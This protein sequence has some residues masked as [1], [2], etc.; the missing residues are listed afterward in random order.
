[1]EFL[2]V[3][4]DTDLMRSTFIAIGLARFI[5][6]LL[7]IGSGLEVRIQDQGSAYIIMLPISIEALEAEVS[8][9]GL[10]PLLRAIKKKPSEKETEK[11][12]ADSDNQLKYKYVPNGFRKDMIAD[13]ELEQTKRDKVRANNQTRDQEA[14]EVLSPD[15]P[16]WAHLVSYFGKGS[17]MKKVYPSLLHTWHAHEGENAVALFRIII[18]HFGQIPHDTAQSLHVWETNILK[19]LTYQ[20]FEIETMVSTASVVSPTGVQ[21]N[22]RE[23]VAEKLNN[24]PAEIFWLEMYFAFTGYMIAGMPYRSEKDVLLYYPLPKNIDIYALQNYMNEYRRDAEVQGLYNQYKMERSKLDALAYLNYYQ[25]LI[26]SIPS[27]GRTRRKEI[28]GLVGYYYRDLGGTQVPFD[29][30]V[31]APPDWLPLG[32]KQE[33]DLAIDLLKE[34]KQ[35]ISRIYG[36]KYEL[37][38]DELVVTN[39]YR[40]FIIQ[41]DA[42]TWI[43]FV[44]SYHLYR[45]ERASEKSI[46]QLTK[47]LVEETLITMKDKVNYR[48]ILEN[49]GFQNIASVIRHTTTTAQYRETKNQNATFR[50]R[51]GL[52]RDLMRR[53]HNAEHFIEDLTNFLYDYSLESSRVTKNTGDD[54]YPIVSSDDIAQIVNLIADYGSRIIA[55]LLVAVG[56]APDFSRTKESSK[57]E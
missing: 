1:M 32:S 4:K 38:S 16:L 25:Q 9:N 26:S 17:A 27:E 3:Q 13:Y 2:Y 33:R 30:V 20:Q 55:H 34:H 51:H 42:Q 29:E 35:I 48:P 24:E 15:Y 54:K 6:S 52:G 56:Y 11:L 49:S 28:I 39:A 8:K 47:Q 46:K 31:F 44:T 19:K 23:T 7:P 22:S 53:S 40:N 57:G 43:D 41:G 10:Q 5:A 21:G 50:V 18:Q 37:T 45:F 12:N 36:P 14:T